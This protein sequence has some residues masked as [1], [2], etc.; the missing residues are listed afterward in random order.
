MTQ[1]NPMREVIA[2]QITVG[3]KRLPLSFWMTSTGRT[4][5]CSLP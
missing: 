1:D 2:A 3:E 5:P 4:P